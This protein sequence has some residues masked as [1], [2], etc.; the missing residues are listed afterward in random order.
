[1]SFFF[2]EEDKREFFKGLKTIRDYSID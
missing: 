1:L 2:L